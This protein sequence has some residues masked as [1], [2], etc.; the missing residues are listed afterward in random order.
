[1]KVTKPVQVLYALFGILYLVIG[2]GS[3]LAAAN[4]PTPSPF[5]LRSSTTWQ[6]SRVDP[7]HRI[8]S[9]SDPN[10]DPVRAIGL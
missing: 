1:M 6:P 4:E 5:P 8:L 3:M 9:G 10:S 2:T 7:A